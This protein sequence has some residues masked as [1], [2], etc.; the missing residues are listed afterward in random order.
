MKAP[1]PSSE[2]TKI[3]SRVRRVSDVLRSGRFQ[4]PWHQ[5]TYDWR[6]EEVDDLLQDLRDALERD[7]TCYFLGSIMLIKS[8]GRGVSRINDGQQRLIT[9]SLLTAAL[10]RRFASARK[11]AHEHIA[12]S[13]LFATPDDVTVV[14]LDD[15]PR[16]EVRIEPP[17]HDRAK[18]RRLLL[19]KNIPAGGLLASAWKVVDN[20]ANSLDPQT[21]VRLFNYLNK[22]VEISVLDIPA[23]VDENLVFETLNAR[24]KPLDDVDLIRNHLYSYFP[25]SEEPEPRQALQENLERPKSDL[26][27]KKL[28]QFFRSFLQ[29]EYGFL[30]ETRFY[31]KARARIESKASRSDPQTY[32]SGLASELGQ[33]ENID[34]FRKISLLDQRET[35]AGNLPHVRGKRDLDVLLRE[36][37]DYSVSYSL[38]F[39]LLHRFLSASNGERKDNNRAIAYGLRNLNSFIMRSRVCEPLL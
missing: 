27:G 29:C 17:T 23:D 16:Y 13:T 19:G 10:C 31:R 24:G 8:P 2:S 28:P 32:V 39:A 33:Q 20:F 12:I 9:I 5:R 11:Q 18:Y 25:E 3:T 36:L 15:A 21:Q 7:K 14:S 1:D 30:E 26:T 34:L 37:K 22:R 6:T 4:V 38:C 35:L